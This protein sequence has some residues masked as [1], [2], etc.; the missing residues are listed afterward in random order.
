MASL[1]AR[2]TGRAQLEQISQQLTNLQ[3]NNNALTLQNNLLQ[4]QLAVNF[5]AQGGFAKYDYNNQ[6]GFIRNGYQ[7]SAAVYSIVKRIAKT[8]AMIAPFRVYE[9][10]D[11]KLM[12]QYKSYLKVG[13]PEA[14][15]KA[16]QIRKKA[17]VEVPENN[18]LQYLLDNPNQTDDAGTFYET[19]IGFRLLTGNSYLHTPTL[20]KGASAGMINEMYVL[21]SQF[22]AIITTFTYPK[23]VLGFELIINGVVLMKSEE[24]IHLKYP[25]YDYSVDGQELYGWSPLK[26][27]ARMLMRSNSAELSSTSMFDNGGPGVIIANKSMSSDDVGIEQA[28]KLKKQWKDEYAGN[29]NRGKMK[30]MAGDIDVHL[31]GLSP[32]DLDILNSEMFTF[33]QICN[34][35]HCSSILFNNHES[36]TYNNVT[37]VMKDFITNA[38]LPEKYAIRDAFNRK[39]TP[40]F[41]KNGKKY[42][43]DC[44]L[45]EISELQ[46]DKKVMTDWLML[47]WGITPNQRNEMLDIARSADP[48]MDKIWMP[49]GLQTMDDMTISVDNLPTDDNDFNRDEIND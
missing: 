18:P 9:V 27:G 21:P 30:L 39:I 15:F 47:N 22:M 46:P 36:S 41:N 49:M 29:M 37:Q 34:L 7:L 3:S 6:I 14:L 25:N 16:E 32:V 23:K 31:L 26:S 40:L 44:D 43:I 2:L 8:A 35:Y 20:D 12:K 24:V 28:G 1:L 45:S 5:R 42:F 13:S 11:D 19:M 17:L 38:V 4:Q 48:N 10:T 33:D